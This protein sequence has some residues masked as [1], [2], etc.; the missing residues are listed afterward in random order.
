MV[1]TF[2]A[3]NCKVLLSI[4]LHNGCDVAE[5]IL[6]F[7]TALHLTAALSSILLCFMQQTVWINVP[8]RS[9]E[10][11]RRDRR[12]PLPAAW[13]TD[14][15]RSSPPTRR[16]RTQRRRPS[17]TWHRDATPSPARCST[18]RRR[19][20]AWDTKTRPRADQSRSATTRGTQPRGR[21]SGPAHSWDRR[22]PGCVWRMRVSCAHAPSSCR[23]FPHPLSWRRR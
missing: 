22:S 13:C 20:R 17:S 4:N 18:F 2:F 9:V 14:A 7:P 15:G 19:Q 1:L 21:R 12:T 6:L 10:G 3:Y 11:F 16:R 5:H 8:G 23:S